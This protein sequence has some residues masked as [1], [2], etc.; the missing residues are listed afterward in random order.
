MNSTDEKVFII[1]KILFKSHQFPKLDCN[2]K[3]EKAK[4]SFIA[5][6]PDLLEILEISW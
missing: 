3:V 2:K 5:L 4:D 6:D 1:P